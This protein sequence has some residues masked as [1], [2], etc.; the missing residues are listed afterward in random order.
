MLLIQGF[1][2]LDTII[3]C[4]FAIE[5]FKVRTDVEKSWKTVFFWKNGGILIFLPL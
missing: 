5:F 2:A 1:G 3:P 4:L